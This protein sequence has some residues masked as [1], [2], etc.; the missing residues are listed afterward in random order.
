MEENTAQ[1]K[2]SKIQSMEDKAK[3]FL[4]LNSILSG[5]WL[6]ILFGTGSRLGDLMF[7]LIALPFITAMAGWGIYCF[8]T[9]KL[10]TA[11]KLE[12]IEETLN[13]TAVEEVKKI[14][15]DAK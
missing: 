7:V 13:K 15:A 4:I 1:K 2:S 11:E 14:I 8:I 5:F 10:Y 6:F 3:A 9:A 12:K